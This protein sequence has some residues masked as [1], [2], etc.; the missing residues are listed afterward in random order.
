MFE[1]V[2]NPWLKKFLGEMK[3]KD[4][5]LL[6]DK[7]LIIPKLISVTISPRLEV[8]RTHCV[9]IYIYILRSHA[10]FPRYCFPILIF[11]VIF[12]P[13]HYFFYT[14]PRARPFNNNSYSLDLFTNSENKSICYF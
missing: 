10:I 7:L 14:T 9:H 4:P 5:N 8:D 2:K 11:P 13:P 12:I 3:G 6:L 1:N